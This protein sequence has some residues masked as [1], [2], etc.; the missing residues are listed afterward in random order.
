[1]TYDLADACANPAQEHDIASQGPRLTLP[2]TLPKNIIFTAAPLLQHSITL[3]EQNDIS[4][5]I[6]TTLPTWM[7]VSY[8]AATTRAELFAQ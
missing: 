8:L 7:Y 1:M 5:D 4:I 3:Q 6:L 2:F